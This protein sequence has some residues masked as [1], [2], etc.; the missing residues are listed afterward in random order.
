MVC[1]V[2][3]V[4]ASFVN[5]LISYLNIAGLELIYSVTLNE[6]NLFSSELNPFPGVVT[7]PRSSVTVCL[8]NPSTKILS[9][10]LNGGEENPSIGG[11]LSSSETM[12]PV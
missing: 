4:P 6:L 9:P 8:S 12:P 3:G 11:V 2:T 5:S 7:L 1:I 10:T